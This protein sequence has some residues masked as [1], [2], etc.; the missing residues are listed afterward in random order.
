MENFYP[1]SCNFKSTLPTLDS[2]YIKPE[3]VQVEKKLQLLLGDKPGRIGQLCQHLL[4]AG[5]KRIRPLL[6]CLSGELFEISNE[7]LINCATALELIHMAS[8]VHD[9]IIDEADSRRGKPSINSIWGNHLAVLTGDFLFSKAFSLLS[10]PQLSPVLKTVT[11]AINSMC[12]GEIE[13]AMMKGNLKQTVAEYLNRI[14]KKTGRLIIASCSVGPLLAETESINLFSMQNYGLYIG[15]AFQIIDDLFDLQ[16]NAKLIGKPTGVDLEQGHLTLPILQL[17]EDPLYNVEA[18]KVLSKIPLSLGSKLEL[19]QLLKNSGAY[20]TTYS[21][22]QEFIEQA[23]AALS[24]FSPSQSVT[25]L[26]A[27][28]D[29]IL[30][31]TI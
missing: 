16:G 7:D 26:S 20:D 29:Y 5:G 19:Q 24:V 13:Q 23:K 11:E 22:A 12:Q 28:A 3:L 14:E 27:L 31:R 10:A 18:K 4:S 21:Q 9:D 2:L 6:A 25:A 15:Y 30:E 1:Y 8:L 17:L